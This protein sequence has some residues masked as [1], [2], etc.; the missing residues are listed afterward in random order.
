MK[1]NLMAENFIVFGK[2]EYS[3]QEVLDVVDSMQNGWIGTGTKVGKFEKSFA[4][5]IGVDDCVAVNSCT[6][7]LHLSLLEAGITYGD[8]VI[9][10]A[11]TFCSTVNSI[12]H[13]GATPILADICSENWNITVENIEAKITERTK[14]ILIVHFAGRP[15]D[16]PKIRSVADRYNLILIEDCAHAIETQISG[17]HVGT[18]G[19]FAAFSFYSTKNISS[20]E[21]GMVIAK[22]GQHVLDNIRRRALHGMDKDAFKRFSADGNAEYDVT[23]IGFKYN[24]MDIQAAIAIHQLKNI[25]EWHIRREKIWK[26]YM[27]ELCNLPLL[28]P[29]N[30]KED[31]IHAFHLFQIMVSIDGEPGIVRSQFRKKLHE[32]GIGTG[33][34]YKSIASFSIYQELFNWKDTNWPNSKFFGDR[35]ISI[36]LSPHLTDSEI[37]RVA[38]AVK[39]SL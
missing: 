18:F 13:V 26:Y 9:T 24:M 4:A 22:G 6:A 28:L 32:R 7:A 34:H 5:Y 31:E 20:G 14:A 3:N 36:P 35:T 29:S 30:V 38:T 33:I 39:E 16:M 25:T 10:T 2:P 27:D 1:L 12:I 15:C 17:S 37:E 8:E 19:D 23:S 21:G 11:M